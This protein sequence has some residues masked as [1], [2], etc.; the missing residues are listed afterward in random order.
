[1]KEQPI[2]SCPICKNYICHCKPISNQ[3]KSDCQQ[4][5]V[6]EGFERMLG[7]CSKDCKCEDCGNKIYMINA[8]LKSQK[9]SLTEEEEVYQDYETLKK[10]AREDVRKELIK[11]V[12]EDMKDIL[13]KH[14]QSSVEYAIIKY[15]K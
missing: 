8:L 7:L 6:D 13:N 2:T 3:S 10:M 11:E 15:F 4:D 14:P 9:E 5:W 12:G 1:M